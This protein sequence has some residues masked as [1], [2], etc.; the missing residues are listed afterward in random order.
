MPEH[1]IGTYEE[2]QVEQEVEVRR[3]KW[4]GRRHRVSGP[5]TG[6]RCSAPSLS[7][8]TRRWNN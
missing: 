7:A 8:A 5:V 4:V 2:W 1:K 6:R 3:D